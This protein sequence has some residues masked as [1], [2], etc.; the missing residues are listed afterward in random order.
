MG[1]ILLARARDCTAAGGSL[2]DSSADSAALSGVASRRSS[3]VVA[4]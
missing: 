2:A 4:G 3:F 1:P